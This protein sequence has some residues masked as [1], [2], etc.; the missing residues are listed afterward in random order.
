MVTIEIICVRVTYLVVIKCQTRA[1]YG[2]KMLFCSQFKG[3]VIMMVRSWQ[4]EPEASG[5][6]VSASMK[7][8]HCYFFFLYTV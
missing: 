2:G 6:I 1:V 7:S 3:V 8:A 4:Q 5:H